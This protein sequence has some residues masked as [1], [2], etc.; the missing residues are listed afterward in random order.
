MQKVVSRHPR[1]GCGGKEKKMAWRDSTVKPRNA[2]YYPITHP[3]TQ[4]EPIRQ[5][6]AHNIRGRKVSWV[7]LFYP[8]DEEGSRWEGYRI[9]GKSWRSKLSWC[10]LQSTEQDRKQMKNPFIEQDV[11]WRTRTEPAVRKSSESLTFTM[12]DVLYIQA[13]DERTECC[14]KWRRERRRKNQGNNHHS[15]K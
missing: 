8:H 2:T 4:R 3:I 15:L 9:A 1:W 6:Q 14:C 5:M 7:R 11:T 13:D 12:I 10:R